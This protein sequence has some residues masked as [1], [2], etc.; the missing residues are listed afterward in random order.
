MEAAAEATVRL[1]GRRVPGL[2]VG[3]RYVAHPYYSSRLGELLG[4]RPFPGTLNFDAGVDWRELA[5]RCEPLVVPETTWE[6][7]RL[8]AVYA[9]R[10]R[11]ETRSGSEEV[12]VIRPLLSRHPP[13]VLEIVACRRLADDLPGDEVRVEITGCGGGQGS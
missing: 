12:L 7:R 2:G 11:L 13:T 3:G 10:A 1:V 5:A 9:W 4:C 8:G 6:G